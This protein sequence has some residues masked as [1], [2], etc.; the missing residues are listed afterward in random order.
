MLENIKKMINQETMK[1]QRVM[2]AKEQVM[3]L[4]KENRMKKMIDNLYFLTIFRIYF[5]CY[6]VLLLSL[7]SVCRNDLGALGMFWT[8]VDAFKPYKTWFSYMVFKSGANGKK[9]WILVHFNKGLRPPITRGYSC[10]LLIFP[11][12]SIIIDVHPM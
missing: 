1:K 11:L 8:K 5:T 3:K 10:N 2:N 7:L 6:L 4:R 9:R 12:L